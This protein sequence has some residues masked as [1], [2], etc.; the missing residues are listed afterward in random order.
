MINEMNISYTQQD[1]DNGLILPDS[2]L[3]KKIGF[4]SERFL[5]GSYLWLKDGVLWLSMLMSREEHKKYLLRLLVHSRNL[6]YHMAACPVSKRMTDILT[7]FGFR[8]APERMMTYF[9]EL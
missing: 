8:D 1:I 6:G 2:E 9:N 5:D 3:G 4:T 7:K